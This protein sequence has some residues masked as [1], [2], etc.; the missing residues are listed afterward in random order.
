MGEVIMKECFLEKRLKP[1]CRGLLKQR[2]ALRVQAGLEKIDV[3]INIFKKEENT[4]IK[5]FWNSCLKSLLFY[6][7]DE[8]KIRLC[9]KNILLQTSSDGGFEDDNLK[10]V[11]VKLNEFISSLVISS[12]KIK[13]FFQVFPSI[14][15]SKRKKILIWREVGMLKR[16]NHEKRMIICFDNFWSIITSNSAITSYRAQ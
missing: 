16:I 5:Y 3:F 13:E 14:E 6:E 1:L 2:S 9:Q 7:K 8:R 15:V 12:L 11:D 4:Q 10:K